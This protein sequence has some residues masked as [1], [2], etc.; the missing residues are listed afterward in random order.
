M[1]LFK[2][3]LLASRK[4]DIVLT[5]VKYHWPIIAE[6]SYNRPVTLFIRFEASIRYSLMYIKYVII[7]VCVLTIYMGHSAG[8]VAAE[9]L[10]VRIPLRMA[11]NKNNTTAFNSHVIFSFSKQVKHGAYMNLEL[12]HVHINKRSQLVKL[13]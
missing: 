9:I 6:V 4:S 13:Y 1:I 11:W 2:C 8:K 10:F 5:T 12:N 7:Y 3:V